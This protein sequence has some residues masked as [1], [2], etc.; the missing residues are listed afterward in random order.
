MLSKVSCLLIKK[1][2]DK[3]LNENL[4]I[5]KKNRV[6][7]ETILKLPSVKLELAKQS[8]HFSGAKFYNALPLV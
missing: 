4:F 5:S 1:C 7:I 6:T 3:K 2:L 8:S